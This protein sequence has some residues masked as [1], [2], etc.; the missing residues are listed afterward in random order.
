MPPWLGISST[1]SVRITAKAAPAPK[2]S[3][4]GKPWAVSALPISLSTTMPNAPRTSTRSW[5][6]ESANASPKIPSHRNGAI[7]IIPAAATTVIAS[8]TRTTAAPSRPAWSR[9]A[10][11]RSGRCTSASE[12]GR[13]KSAS[14]QETATE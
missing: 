9:S 11:A 8:A 12:V 6:V 10:R 1:S 4:S 5:P 3:R 2:V 14:A 7:R 13:K